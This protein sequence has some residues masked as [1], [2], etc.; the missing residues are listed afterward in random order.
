MSAVCSLCSRLAARMHV[1]WSV[2]L[3]STVVVVVDSGPT[4]A[5]VK[6]SSFVPVPLTTQTS[7]FSSSLKGS[8]CVWTSTALARGTPLAGGT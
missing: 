7:S 5:M 6:G 8:V 1:V 2:K 3:A 4:S